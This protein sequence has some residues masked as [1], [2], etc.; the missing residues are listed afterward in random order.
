MEVSAT[1]PPGRIEVIPPRP[2]RSAVW[3][4]GEWSW[5]RQRWAWVEGRWVDPPPAASFS[6]WVFERGTDG[7]MWYAPGIWRR[8]DGAPIDPPPP[9]ASAHVEPTQIVNASGAVETTGPTRSAPAPGS[10]T[11]DGGRS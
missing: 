4:D 3:I 1:P 10:A 6:P 9:L 11:A 8:A 5:H 2:N 7:R